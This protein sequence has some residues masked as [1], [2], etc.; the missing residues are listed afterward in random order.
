[1]K[2]RPPKS[3]VADTAWELGVSRATLYRLVD[4]YKS[5]GT[6]EALQPKATGRRAGS[7]VL[8][9]EA[10][11][12]IERAIREVYL[13]PTRPT[14]SHL[15]SNIHEG[16]VTLPCGEREASAPQELSGHCDCSPPRGH[17]RSAK[18]AVRLGGD[19]MALDVEGIVD[20]GVCGKKFLG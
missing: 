3:A 8:P 17:R 2:P 14:L 16:V 12:V 4:I 10:E 5:A 20:G 9:R 19:E 6:V 18:R 7:W 11:E 15:V 13:K 1:H